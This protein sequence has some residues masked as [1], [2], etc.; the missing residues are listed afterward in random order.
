M[1]RHKK[2]QPEV[3][4]LTERDVYNMPNSRRISLGIAIKCTS[5]KQF[6]RYFHDKMSLSQKVA[7][8]AI[9]KAMK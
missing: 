2:W 5:P 1:N 4:Q 6:V 3:L 7:D 8:E 9:K